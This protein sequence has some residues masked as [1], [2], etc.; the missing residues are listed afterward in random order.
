[1]RKRWTR[2]NG[3]PA[4]RASLDQVSPGLASA[5]SVPAPSRAAVL[6]CGPA[7][8]LLPLRPP[9]RCKLLAIRSLNLRAEFAPAMAAQP[10]PL[11]PAQAGSCAAP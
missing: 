2:V 7:A 5:P 11:E 3:S 9:S 4:L 10:L 1:M 6:G 8:T